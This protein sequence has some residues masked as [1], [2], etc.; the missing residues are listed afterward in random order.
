M[1]LLLDAMKEPVS[2]QGAPVSARIP[3]GCSATVI[4]ASLGQSLKQVVP[5]WHAARSPVAALS[6]PLSVAVHSGGPR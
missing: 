1:A 6:F 4:N 2:V 5:E 3:P